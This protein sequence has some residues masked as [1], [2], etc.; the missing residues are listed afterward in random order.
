MTPTE[1][2]ISILLPGQVVA[3]AS[4]TCFALEITSFLAPTS[5]H[6]DHEFIAPKND[7]QHHHHGIMTLID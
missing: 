2:E 5:F 6:I 4:L 1:H 3:S 7:R